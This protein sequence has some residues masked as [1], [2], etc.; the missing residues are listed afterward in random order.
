MRSSI[1]IV[2]FFVIGVCVGLIR[3][4][5][6]AI[7]HNDYSQWALYLLLFLI[8]VSVGADPNS[9]KAVREL[10][11]RI[12]LIPVIT[13]VG[14]TLGIVSVYLF[15][16]IDFTDA[17]AVGYGFGYYSLSSIFIT[18]IRGDEWVLLPCCRIFSARLSPLAAPAM[19]LFL[20]N[21]LPLFR[22]EP[23]AR[24]PLYPL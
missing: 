23:P 13:I 3:F 14:T 20:G 18:E 11:I 1:V 4:V 24:I 9:I 8:G 16:K 21:W 7:I 5:P 17:L 19:A 22:E 10:N 12:V 15:M 6:D 2:S